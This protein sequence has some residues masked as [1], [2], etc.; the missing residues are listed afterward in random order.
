MFRE[1]VATGGQNLVKG[2]NNLLD[3]IERGNGQLRIS[4]T[5]AKAFE[6]GVNIATTPGKVVFQNDLMQ[7]IQY[8]P[9]TQEGCEAAA[10]DHPAVDQQVLHPRPAREELVHALGG[11]PG[12]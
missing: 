8:E 9:T 1:T 3:D 4:M 2:L 10:A 11:R 7:L 6:L 5:D 12:P